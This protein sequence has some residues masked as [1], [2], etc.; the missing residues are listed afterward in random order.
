VV[1]A[2]AEAAEVNVVVEAAAE[3]AEVV[4]AE[5]A[6]V[7][8]VVEMAKVTV[9]AVEGAVVKVT[10]VVVEAAGV[11]AGAAMIPVVEAD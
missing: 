8:G 6:P 4:G 3:V 11:V 7:R 1:G 10:A 5:P 9:E 2:V